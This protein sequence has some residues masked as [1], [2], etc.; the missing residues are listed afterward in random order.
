MMFPLTLILSIAMIDSVIFPLVERTVHSGNVKFQIDEYSH[1]N[2]EYLHHAVDGAWS[3]MISHLDKNYGHSFKVLVSISNASPCSLRFVQWSNLKDSRL[4]TFGPAALIK[5][6]Y[7]SMFILTADITTESQ[8]VLGGA[9]YQ[10]I[11]DT[12]HGDH[13]ILG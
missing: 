13:A 2:L 1:Q 6:G 12:D 9:V 7:A 5:P 3:D 8:E 10:R 11:N 4:S